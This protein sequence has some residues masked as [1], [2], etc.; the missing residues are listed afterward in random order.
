[1]TGLKTLIRILDDA[2]KEGT[3]EL[4]S[5]LFRGRADY[6][7]RVHKLLCRSDFD[8]HTPDLNALLESIEVIQDFAETCPETAMKVGLSVDSA[9][10]ISSNKLSQLDEDSLASLVSY[11]ALRSDAIEK[12]NSLPPFDY[13]RNL[14]ELE[15]L[16]THE[17]TYLLDDRLLNFH[18]N[19]LATAMTLRDNIRQKRRFPRKEFG[20]LKEAFPCIIAGIRDYAEY[21]PLE[22][23]IFDLVVIDEA[24]QVSIA[25]AFPAL[26][27]AKKVVVLG[28]K[29]QF[30]N[31]K[32][33]QARSDTNRDWLNR[34]EISFRSNVSSD[35]AELQRLQKFNI[36][37]SILEFFEFTAN[38]NIMLLKHFRGYREHI[39]YS[40]KYFYGGD[41][42]AIKIRGKSIDDVLKFTFITHDSKVETIENTNALEVSFILSEL[43]RL[44]ESEAK[45]SVGVI[46]PHTN[47]QKLVASEVSKLP[48]RDY[49]YDR[50]KLKVMTFDTCQGEER[51]VVYYS[52]V[53]NPLSDRL[54]GV[55]L[56]DLNDVDIEVGGQIKAQ[57]LNVGFSRVK[58][59]MN[60]VL[61]KPIDQ[62]KGSIREALQ[63]Y[64]TVLEEGRRLPESADV[65]PSSPMEH[66][67]LEWVKNT[68]FLQLHSSAIDLRA[69][70][71]V[72][73]YLKQLDRYYSHPKYR[74]DFLMIYTEQDGTQHKI[75]IEYDGF[76]EHFE[77][78]EAVTR[79]NYEYYY[80]EEDLEREK[81]L[82]SYGYKFIRVNRFNLGDDPVQV[83][84]GRLEAAVTRRPRDEKLSLTS[85]IHDTFGQLVKREVKVCPRC[86]KVKKI[87][88]FWDSSLST[89]EGRICKDCKGRS[90][91]LS[92][93]RA[94]QKESKVA[95]KATS[96]L[97]PI[98]RSPMVL[99][100]G[101]YGE[102]YGCSRFP[103]CKGTRRC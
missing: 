32:S 73:E 8:L 50:L 37:T 69:Q 86:G 14:E 63:H 7:Q 51:D 31:V 11:I 36:K 76:R 27:R 65:D 18:E 74:V 64:Q 26:I 83:L 57:R 96:V 92:K 89:G 61:S 97:C 35:P 55:F 54:W 80:R 71:P 13:Q 72:G 95:E 45:V 1:L 62:F 68:K 38:F 44:K 88:E 60:F 15:E 43:R 70:F 81:I 52:M 67:L 101:R 21:I 19:N 20:K 2:K 91:S 84:N 49:F 40:S 79:F 48:D 5:A 90:K 102:F 103:R 42:Q 17:M 94:K 98:C 41:L 6:L 85:N 77:Q 10:T 53:A 34:L 82:E 23:G 4:V 99:R 24:S 30:S 16:L 22:P 47:Q 33:A 9:V 87:G 29:K 39:S 58:E 12:F 25:Q 75:I 59:C 28:D 78:L 3:R 93:S 100:S 66:K 56:K 46:T